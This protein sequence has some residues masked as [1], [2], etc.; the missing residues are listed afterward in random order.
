MRAANRL[1][2][3]LFHHH[4]DYTGSAVCFR[5]GVGI[6]QLGETFG[7]ISFNAV[8]P[9]R[10]DSITIRI[11]NKAKGEIYSKIF[12]FNEFLG[13][14]ESQ[15]FI[16]DATTNNLKERYGE[17]IFL[18]SKKIIGYLNEWVTGYDIGP[19]DIE[20]LKDALNELASAIH[21]FNEQEQGLVEKLDELIAA[22]RE[23]NTKS[24][25]SK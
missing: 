2:T 14:D 12:H 8:E 13:D 9:N 7:E 17:G 1:G 18:I 25:R 24:R 20:E 6:Y 21:D 16:I 3:Y 19:G 23:I 10:F 4:L 11:I 5:G 22:V 15:P